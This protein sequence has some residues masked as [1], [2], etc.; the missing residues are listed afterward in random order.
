MLR[1]IPGSTAFVGIG[2]STSYDRTNPNHVRIPANHKTGLSLDS[3]AICDDWI[4]I[5]ELQDVE[6]IGH[7]PVKE[8]KLIQEVVKRLS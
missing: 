6:R 5:M 3:A 2:I 8:I 1:L 4:T 7:C